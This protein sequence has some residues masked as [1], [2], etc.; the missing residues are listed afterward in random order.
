MDTRFIAEVSSNHQQDLDRCLEFVDTS[1]RVGCHA[2]K[3]QLFRLD[4]LFAPEIVKRSEMHAK[5]R[6]WELPLTFLPHIAKR[7][8][9]RQ[10]AFGCTPFYLEAVNE[11]LPF[12]DFYKVSSYELLW[13]ELLT[14]CARAGKPVILS[15]GMATMD[16]V[17]AAVAVLQREGCT[18]LTL[19]QCVSAYP[20]P[21]NQC[22]LRVIDTFRKTFNVSAGWSDHSVSPSVLYRAIW[23]HHSEVIEFHLDID[24]M[25]AEFEAGHCWM[26]DDIAQVIATVKDSAQFEGDGNKV[27]V[28]AELPDRDWRAD[29]SDG[30][31]PFL[32]VRK[33]WQP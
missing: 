31:R 33:D 20:A 15:T 29:P 25:G 12:V 11:L 14:Q 9:E 8:R 22:N 21:V 4:D 27:P 18:D 32:H 1:A 23:G 16:E 5:R 3:F 30:L 7:C 24:G 6:A 13:T 26:P 17:A 28:P 2:V 19:L 10:I